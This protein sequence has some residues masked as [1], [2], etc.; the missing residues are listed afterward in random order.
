MAS[1]AFAEQKQE[2]KFSKEYHF[3]PRS[4]VAYKVSEPIEIDGD[5]YKDVWQKAPWTEDFADIRGVEF[6]PQ[7][8]YRTRAKML[9]DDDYLYI[10]AELEE[11]DIWA[12]ITDRDATMYWDND[13]EVFIDPD[14]D[15]HNYVEFE[16]NAFNT[17]W[18]LFFFKPYYR[19][20]PYRVEWNMDKLKTAVKIYGTINDPSDKD[21]KWTVELAFPIKEISDTTIFEDR[22]LASAEH[23][24][25]N[26]SRVNWLSVEAVD[27]KY[28]KTKGKEGFGSEENWV[29]NPTGR[30]D[31]HR[32][33]RWGYLQ[34]SDIIAGQGVEEFKWNP[35]ENIKFGL[36]TLLHRQDEFRNVN[37][38][39]A[40]TIEELQPESIDVRGVS[41]KPVLYP[42]GNGY[43]ISAPSVTG[44]FLW[45]ITFDGRVFRE[46]KRP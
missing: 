39:F 11:P 34:F 36:R 31:M 8:Q 1:A 40:E 32:P 26:F 16:M 24:R 33:E 43:K 25:I 45:S 12:N 41:F 9:W 6:D 35:D 46:D 42:D 4:Y 19:W 15:T 44:D 27:G 21:D 14:N 13:F 28:V 7:P 30:V 5:I 23:W 29:W 10:A 22:V 18:D 2:V 20:G 17:V 38:R 37:E 3:T